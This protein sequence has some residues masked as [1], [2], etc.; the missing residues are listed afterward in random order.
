M[1]CIPC[2]GKTPVLKSGSYTAPNV[3]I[4]GN[5]V[6]EEGASIWYNSV[7]RCE[8]GYIHIGKNVAVEDSVVIHASEQY[9][10]MLKEN[11]V[12][13]HAAILHGC[14][15][16]KNCLIGMGAILMN[17]CVIG[18]NCLIAAGS[19]VTQGVV[20]TEGSM[21]MGSP[22]KVKR[23]LTT[24]ELETVQN[25]HKVYLEYSEMQLIKTR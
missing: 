2:N 21:V 18:D 6:L 4:I 9:P 11:A 7:A 5:V 3:S 13:G 17:G 23:P 8:S 19:L 10:V 14:T 1:I 22:A 25:T 24:D 20:I 16:G 15:V 12:I